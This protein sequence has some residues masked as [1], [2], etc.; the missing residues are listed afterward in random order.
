VTVAE[1]AKPE[2][3]GKADEP[4]KV[5]GA[6]ETAATSSST[7]TAA[8][9]K[10]ETPAKPAKAGKKDKRSPAD[11]DVV[12]G[13]DGP[14]QKGSGVELKKL[15]IQLAR[16]VGFVFLV[17]ALILA[18]AALCIALEANP[19]NSF[20]SFVLDA[21]KAVDLGVFDLENPIKEFG[22]AN[23][24]TKEALL[25][26]GLGAIVYLVVGRILE[27]IIRP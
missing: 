6:S 8:S 17:L 20:V 10:P 5:D 18:A 23:G 15:R 1:P 21:A 13:G 9:S 2:R 22:G 12:P 27:R 14:R 4:E 26:Y 24:P 16:V 7:A 19:D 25:N 11:A 3:S